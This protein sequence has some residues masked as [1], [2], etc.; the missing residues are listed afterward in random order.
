VSHHGITQANKL[1]KPALQAETSAATRQMDRQVNPT[2]KGQVRTQ[3]LAF[4]PS[5]VRKYP[6]V[7]TEC[8]TSIVKACLCHN[9]TKRVTTTAARKGSN[10]FVRRNT[11]RLSQVA[12]RPSA[13]HHPTMAKGHVS[14]PYRPPVSRM[15]NVAHSPITKGR[16]VESATSI[17]LGFSGTAIKKTQ[18]DALLSP[19]IFVP[20]QGEHTIA[21]KGP[22]KRGNRR[23]GYQPVGKESV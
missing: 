23:S 9:Q 13:T 12:E 19:Y 8:G 2:V 3:N 7:R 21:S 22:D 17:V 11:T 15:T 14:C 6:Y 18:F 20:I 10:V 5:G 1:R 16:M 4:A